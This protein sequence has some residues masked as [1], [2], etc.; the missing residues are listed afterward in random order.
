MVR[1]KD[2]GQTI[3]AGPARGS[4]TPFRYASLRFTAPGGV[5]GKIIVVDGKK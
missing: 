1:G 5:T 4:E 3:G 2:R